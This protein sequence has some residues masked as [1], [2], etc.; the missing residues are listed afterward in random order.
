M[1]ARLPGPGL[2]R[3]TRAFADVDLSGVWLGTLTVPPVPLRL[4]FNLE[5]APDGG[6]TGTADSPDQ[7]AFGL[8]LSSVEVDGHRVVVRLD[9]IG[10]SFTGRCRAMVGRCRG[11]LSKGAASFPLTLEWQSEPLDYRR[12]QDPVAPFP[13]NSADV[14]FASEQPGVSLAGTLT[15]PE[16]AGPFPA[17]V[18]ISGSG[19]QNRNE[20]LLNHRPFL[21]LA[22]ALTRAGVVVLRYDD[23]R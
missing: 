21:V 16:G 8:P 1:Q 9:A 7:A 4:V 19:G 6:W 2:P 23:P 5:R 14:T 10:A 18:L 17:A 11:S 20:E 3:R 15:W 12:P 22:D 13:Y